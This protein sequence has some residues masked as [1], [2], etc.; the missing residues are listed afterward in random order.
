MSK[1]NKFEEV[2][3][4]SLMLISILLVA[5]NVLLRQFSMGI[6]WTEELIRYLI[7]WI[8]FIGAS[9]CIREGSHI[10]IDFLQEFTK[11]KFKHYVNVMVNVVCIIF[12][13]LLTYYAYLYLVDIGEK[14]QLSPAMGIPIVYFY[15]VILISAVLMLIRYI[16]N[17][18]L[19][20]KQIKTN[21]KSE[22]KPT[23]ILLSEAE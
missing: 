11:G 1:L 7:V 23:T 16:E 2:F 19:L 8:T 20:V 17:L 21:D 9:I 18:V 22:V 6:A 10:S 3:I 15:S 12:S 5:A 4:G 13:V 14:N